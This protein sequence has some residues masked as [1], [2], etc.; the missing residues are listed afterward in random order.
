M[1]SNPESDKDSDIEFA[2]NN[3]FD[4]VDWSFAIDRIPLDYKS[5][6]HFI[7]Q[8]R[9]LQNHGIEVRFHT[10]FVNAE[11]GHRDY[12]M[13]KS[14]MGVYLRILKLIAEAG[15]QFLTLHTG[16]GNISDEVICLKMLKKNL[17]ILKN[18]GLTHG[19]TITLENL[20]YGPTSIP[21]KWFELLEKTDIPA[22]F[23]FGHAKA[24]DAVSN[25]LWSPV[26][27]LNRVK[28]RLIHA[29]IYKEENG[30]GH[31]PP[32]TIDD[33]GIDLL[34]ALI[35]TRCRWWVIELKER[36]TI[37]ST[38]EMLNIYIESNRVKF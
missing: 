36:H 2:I 25:G 10:P 16:L 19:V 35:K 23:D 18:F 24:C 4:G 21:E 34:D 22:T 27:I 3:G 1:S 37:L 28:G 17:N 29:H 9:R 8:I 6:P 32:M 11:I 26:R 38:K 5:K 7:S 12:T 14:A 31:V 15:G 30:D 13:S 20:R 33:L